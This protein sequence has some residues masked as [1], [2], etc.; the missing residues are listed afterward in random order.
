MT[1]KHLHNTENLYCNHNVKR[2]RMYTYFDKFFVE[3]QFLFSYNIYNII[4]ISTNLIMIVL[5]LV[6][7]IKH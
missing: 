5:S 3:I 2:R 4:H 1:E 6:V 7:N